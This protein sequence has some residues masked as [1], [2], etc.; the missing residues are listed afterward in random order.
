ME[1]AVT[2]MIMKCEFTKAFLIHAFSEFAKT[3]LSIP[4]YKLGTEDWEL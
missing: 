4:N 2:E 3:R 1:F